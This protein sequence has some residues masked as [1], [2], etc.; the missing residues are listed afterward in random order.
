MKVSMKNQRFRYAWICAA[1]LW[2]FFFPAALCGAVFTVLNTNSSGPGSL[3]QAADDANSVPGP[4]Q[5]VFAIPGSGVHTIDLSNAGIVLGYS[6]TIDG[7][8]QPGA[9]PNT[10]S[11]GDNAVILIQLDGGGPLGQGFDGLHI[12]GDDC[13]VRGLSFTGFSGPA[14]YDAAISLGYNFGIPEGGSHRNRIEGNFIGLAP[15]GVTLGGNN[16]GIS[17]GTLA[18]SNFIGGTTPA[19]RNIIAGNRTGIFAPYRVTILGNYLGTDASGLRQG[20]GNDTAIVAPS[21][22]SLVPE[23]QGPGMLSRA[24]WS[25][26]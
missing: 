5:I 13:V 22:A 8:T 12:D 10:L 14:S 18:D 19:A 11:V 9:S 20:Y 6:I 26:L 1:S 16:Y 23:S 7:Y 15:D 2:L 3:A 21:M 4:N 24:M 25:G 17:F